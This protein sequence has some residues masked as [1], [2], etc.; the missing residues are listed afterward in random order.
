M[1]SLESQ[2]SDLESE[3][4]RLLRAL[5]QAKE[6][7]ADVER[8]E[9]KRA[10]DAAKELAVQVCPSHLFHRAHQEDVTVPKLSYR[11]L[12]LRGSERRSRSLPTMMRSSENWR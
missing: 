11:L 6:S 12:R 5:D 1:K 3:A 8:T 10:D 2:I 7:K 4:S 9:K